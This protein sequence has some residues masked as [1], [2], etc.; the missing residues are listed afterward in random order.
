MSRDREEK[1]FYRDR[2]VPVALTLEN[3]EI[4]LEVWKSVLI[5]ASMLGSGCSK[6]DFS[7]TGAKDSR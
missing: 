5:P 4:D 1:G 3:L 6:R 7:S 2:G